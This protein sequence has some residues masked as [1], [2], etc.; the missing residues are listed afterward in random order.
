MP[1][2]TISLRVAVIGAARRSHYLYGPIL[3]ALS[4]QVELIG[5]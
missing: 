2:Q 5:V 1:T 4:G 3:R